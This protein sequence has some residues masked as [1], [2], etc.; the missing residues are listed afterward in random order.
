[1]QITNTTARTDILDKTLIWLIG[2]DHP[3]VTITSRTRRNHHHRQH[4]RQLDG[5]R[6]RGIGL[7]PLAVLLG[8]RWCVVDDHQA[9][10]PGTSPYSWN[11]SGLQNGAAYRVRLAVTDDG[12]VALH[13]TDC[14]GR[15]LHH[16]TRGGRRRRPDGAGRVRK[17]PTRTR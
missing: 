13:G 8:G 14:L 2:R 16:R 7:E 1:V 11:V 3:D 10:S 4:V 17:P 15:Q 6:V 5:N 9:I 12:A